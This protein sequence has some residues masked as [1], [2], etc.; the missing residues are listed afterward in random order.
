MPESQLTE[1]TTGRRTRPA[2]AAS[3]RSRVRDRNSR[4]ILAA[5]G[6]FA[7][8][9]DIERASMRELAEVAEVSVRTL[10]NLFDD[11]NGLVRALVL[12]SIADVN[13][14]VGALDATEPIERA[15]EAVEVALTMVTDALPRTVLAAVLN[16]VELLVQ[17]ARQWNVRDVLTD[18]IRRAQQSGQLFDDIDAGLLV[19]QV[20]RTLF[21]LLRGWAT[22]LIDDDALI[23]GTLHAL[24]ICLLAIARPEWRETVRDHA[25]ALTPRL[26]QP[27]PG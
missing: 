8:S 9:H 1:P 3:A 11:R 19:D 6:E 17:L 7:A 4:R 18:E 20:G 15:W 27:V 16:D 24:D 21:N 10:Y 5:V 13:V 14:A 12:D 2:G 25:D 22:G 23:A 26:R